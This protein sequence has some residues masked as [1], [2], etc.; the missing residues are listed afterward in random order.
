MESLGQEVS[1]IYASFCK[2]VHK[3]GLK[4]HSALGAVWGEHDLQI[5]SSIRLREMY[6]YDSYPKVEPDSGP[7]RAVRIFAPPLCI[8]HFALPRTNMSYN[9]HSLEGVIWGI[10]LGSIIG[11][12]K[13][14]PRSLD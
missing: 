9:P 13:G 11:V 7:R 1:E 5:L 10:I 3:S 12:I 14:A 2:T 4:V 6:N 8:P